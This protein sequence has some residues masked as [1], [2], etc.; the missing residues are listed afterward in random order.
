MKNIL[1]IMRK[2]FA[3]FFK[4]KRL[5]LGTLILPG[6]LIFAVYTLMGSAFTETEQT[7]TVKVVHSSP[8]FEQLFEGA[9]E[10][11]TVVTPQPL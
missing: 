7:Y 6:V 2:E 10:E 1:T 11:I 5:V 8:V 3:R 4:D 9:E